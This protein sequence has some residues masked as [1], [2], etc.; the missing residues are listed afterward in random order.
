MGGQNPTGIALPSKPNSAVA[1]VQTRS[2]RRRRCHRRKDV[3][4][5][6]F[7]TPA[8]L[9]FSSTRGDP[10]KLP[11]IVQE[12][13]SDSSLP[14][15]NSSTSSHPSTCESPSIGLVGEMPKNSPQLVD[16]VVSL[17]SDPSLSPSGQCPENPCGGVLRPFSKGK[18]KPTDDSSSIFSIP[19]VQN[20]SSDANQTNEFFS[21]SPVRVSAIKYMF[22]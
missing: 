7:D 3:N 18:H 11:D 19:P 8:N 1:F 16:Q 20:I 12:S 17:T 22:F 13:D 6:S 2:Q 10:E 15:S 14:S 5:P 9:H 4:A 21:A